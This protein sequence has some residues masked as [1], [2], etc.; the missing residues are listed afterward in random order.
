MWTND[1]GKGVSVF[2]NVLGRLQN[3]VDL[4]LV[5][6]QLGVGICRILWQIVFVRFSILLSVRIKIILAA[7]RWYFRKSH[8]FKQMWSKA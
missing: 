6:L 2:Q 4:L 5:H 7:Y 8:L 3:L 1:P